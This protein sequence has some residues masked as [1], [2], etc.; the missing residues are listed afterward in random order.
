M[1]WERS[2]RA[3]LVAGWDE[4]WISSPPV[5]FNKFKFVGI[6][7]FI[8]V[9]LWYKLPHR[10][11]RIGKSEW[12]GEVLI[13]RPIHSHTQAL[14]VGRVLGKWHLR[15]CDNRVKCCYES[16]FMWWVFGK[17]I[18]DNDDNNLTV[19]NHRIKISLLLITWDFLNFHK[20]PLNTIRS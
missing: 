10:E 16:D 2:Q 11:E 20:E 7:Q 17:N 6:C 5:C 15:E 8:W 14:A 18:Y 1:E 3:V 4:G 9:S 13:E 19:I 12:K